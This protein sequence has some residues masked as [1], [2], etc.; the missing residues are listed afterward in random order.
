FHDAGETKVVASENTI[1]KPATEMTPAKPTEVAQ[2]IETPKGC[3]FKTVFGEEESNVDSDF[4]LKTPVKVSFAIDEALE[5]MAKAQLNNGGYGA[6][7]H[8]RQGV[9]D[10]HAVK[11]DPATTAMVSMAILRSGSTLTKG[12]YAS[13]LKDA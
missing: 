10:P 2:P 8:A 1:E 7:T 12:P 5:W 11:A 4:I 3:V 13:N 9:T 6:G